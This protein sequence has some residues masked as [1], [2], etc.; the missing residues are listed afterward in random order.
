MK[1]HVC[2][3]KAMF[4]KALLDDLLEFSQTNHKVKPI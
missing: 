2:I 4:G 1:A 3:R